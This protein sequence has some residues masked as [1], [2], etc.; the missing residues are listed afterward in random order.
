MGLPRRP[1]AAARDVNCRWRGTRSSREEAAE[2]GAQAKL[3]A[4]QTRAVS[5]TPVSAVE[6]PE[7]LAPAGDG[8]ATAALAGADASISG[9]TRASTRARAKNFSPSCGRRGGIVRAPAHV[10]LNTPLEPSSRTWRVVP[11]SGGGADAP[12]V[13]DLP[14]PDRAA[15]ARTR[16]HASTQM[17]I[18]SAEGAEI[19]RGLGFTR[20]V[21]PRELSVDE[22]RRLAAGTELE[23]E[24]F[25][26]GALCVSWSGQCLTSES[27]GGRSANRGQCAQSC[28]L[29][30]DLVVDGATQDL[31]DVRYLLSP[32]DLAGASVVPALAAI[33]VHGLKIEGRQKG[34]LRRDG[35]AGY[36]R[37]VVLLNG[38]L[39]HRCTGAL[40]RDMRDMTL[41]TAGFSN[42]FAGSDHQTLVEGRFPNTAAHCWD[43]CCA[44]SR[45]QYWLHWPA[46]RGRQARSHDG[47]GTARRRQREFAARRRRDGAWTRARPSNCAG[48]VS[49]DAGE[50]EDKQEPGGP[51]RR[52]RGLDS[53]SSLANRGRARARRSPR[54]GDQ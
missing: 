26:H 18:S 17:T 16:V 33:G 38:G 40:S 50:P 35:V 2:A 49:F 28:R 6:G 31:G 25:I 46:G 53:A 10:T 51:S 5:A 43:A 47:R 54:V 15:V 11:V 23:L 12:I 27:W 36:R 39:R 4:C 22:I 41:L 21:V 13:Q 8:G 32:S 3:M 24:V 52:S 42:G 30:Y 9:S 44:S 7:V 48:V 14:S 1:A 37:Y 20:V 19:A 34:R 29:P 45:A